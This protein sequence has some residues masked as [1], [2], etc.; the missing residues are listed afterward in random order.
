MPPTFDVY[1]W[2]DSRDQV[3]VLA[4]FIDRYVDIDQ[5]GDPRFDAFFRTFVSRQPHPE[6]RP[7]WRSCVMRSPLMA[8][9]RCTCARSFMQGQSSR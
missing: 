1:V 7:R 4:R 8:L 2:V 3:D 9:S 5:P 6:I